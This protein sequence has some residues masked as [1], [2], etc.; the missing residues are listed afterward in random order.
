MATAHATTDPVEAA[1]AVM[2][3][4][5][6]EMYEDWVNGGSLPGWDR[7]KNKEDMGK[8]KG[9][10]K[11]MARWLLG[12]QAMFK[13]PAVTKQNVVWLFVHLSWIGQLVDAFATVEGMKKGMLVPGKDLSKEELAEYQ[14][15]RKII[16]AAA[17]RVGEIK[18][19]INQHTGSVDKSIKYIQGVE[20]LYSRRMK[21]KHFH[22]APL[23]KQRVEMGKRRLGAPANLDDLKRMRGRNV[24]GDDNG[25]DRSKRRKLGRLVISRE[26]SPTYTPMSPVMPPAVGAQGSVEGGEIL[27]DVLGATMDITQ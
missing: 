12:A 22:E 2:T 21:T 15:C 18:K 27:E 14:T 11:S 24:R 9:N 20:E 25:D 7:E 3:P 13:D 16:A 6:L 1:K 8:W 23:N 4:M 5:Q 19:L 17:F 10:E 26:A